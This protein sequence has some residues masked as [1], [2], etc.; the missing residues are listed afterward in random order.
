MDT[1]F[2]EDRL[3]FSVSKLRREL[4]EKIE[5]AKKENNQQKKEKLCGQ[6]E[7]IKDEI[8]YYEDII[9]YAL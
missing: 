4:N 3:F 2:E 6:I 7:S 5:E 8:D 9:S 1:N